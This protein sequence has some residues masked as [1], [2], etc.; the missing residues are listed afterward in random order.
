MRKHEK[1][2]KRRGK[3]LLMVSLV[4]ASYTSDGDGTVTAQGSGAYGCWCGNN[5]PLPTEDPRPVDAWD[6]ACRSHDLC[7]RRNGRN[8]R[9]CDAR[10]LD[11]LTRLYYSYG[12]IPG[13]IQAGYTH[14][15]SKLTG[16]PNYGMWITPRDIIS[17]FEAGTDCP[18]RG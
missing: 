2:E 1:S 5:F 4:L 3:I 13:Q 7:Y 15:R 12:Y 8:S 17:Y 11:D 10:F 9:V 6:R 18:D 14:F 16:I